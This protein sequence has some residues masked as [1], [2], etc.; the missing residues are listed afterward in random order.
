MKPTLKAPGTLPLKL[1][2]DIPL[3]NVAFIFNLRRYMMVLPNPDPTDAQFRPV[4]GRGLTLRNF[5]W[6]LQWRSPIL[7][8]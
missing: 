6:Y 1:K 3:S 4:H 2:Y 8:K 7:E 5:P